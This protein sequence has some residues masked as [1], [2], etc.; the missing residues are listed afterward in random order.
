MNAPALQLQDVTCTFS[1]RRDAAPGYT[2]LRN[3]VLTVGP[4]EFVSIVGPSGCGKSTLLSVAAGLVQ[5]SAGQVLTFGEPLTGLNRRAGYVFQAESLLPWRTALGNAMAGLQFRGV[6]TVEARARAEDWLRRVG[7]ADFGDRYPHQLS[8]G[9]RKRASL[10]QALVLEPDLILMDEPFSALDA[11]TRELVENEL[12]QLWQEKKRAVLFVTHDLDEA[13][14]LS[15]RVVVMS[16]GPDAH[17]VSE[18]AIDLPR[19][20]DVA[21]VRLTARFIE[22]H[23]AIRAVLRPQV[24]KSFQT[25]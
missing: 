12:L 20:R 4:Q 1:G 11:Q 16:A 25:Q 23:H 7:L 19:P 18:F 2:A 24:L 15:D 6:R 17:I 22:L 8:G 21:E 3:A 5:P 13:I 10:A 9:M 14:A